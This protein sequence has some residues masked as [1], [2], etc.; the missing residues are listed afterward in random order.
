[1][2]SEPVWPDELFADLDRTGQTPYYSQISARLGAAIREGVIP[3]GARLPNELNIGERLGVSRPTIRQAI[4]ALVDDGLLVRRRGVGTQVVQA[5]LNRPVE[6]TS[7]HEDLTR[8]GHQSTTQVLTVERIPASEEVAAQLNLA[9]GSE[10]LRIRRLRSSNGVAMA[11]LENFLPY[12]FSNITAAELEDRGLY[13]ILRTRGVTFKIANQ[14]IG[15]RR[16]QGDE[17]EL[18]NLAKGSPLITMDRVAFDHNGRAIEAG[19]H[20]YRPDL[21]SF[22]TTLVA[23]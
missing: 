2:R 7:L 5:R 21:Y 9:V 1:M 4:Q 13:E 14:T 10:I 6:L 18:L 16:T 20:C 8:G 22:T 23:R 12:D 17:D 19:H 3:S 11:I 15:A